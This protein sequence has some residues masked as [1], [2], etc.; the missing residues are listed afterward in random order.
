MEGIWRILRIM[1]GKGQV[2]TALLPWPRNCGIMNSSGRVTDENDC[3]A[4]CG[5]IHGAGAAVAVPLRSVGSGRPDP[6]WM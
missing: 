1:T 2:M 3:G 4:Q 5:R 6:G